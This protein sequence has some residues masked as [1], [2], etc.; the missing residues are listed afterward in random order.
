[1]PV[2]LQANQSTR[3]SGI[4]QSQQDDTRMTQAATVHDLPEIQVIRDEDAALVTRDGQHLI[5]A[6]SR[7]D[8]RYWR[9]VVAERPEPLND[10]RFDVF[11]REE[12]H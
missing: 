11:I 5:V 2:T 7:C 1:M 9:H 3:R 6:D 12:S 10:H 4:G 8:L